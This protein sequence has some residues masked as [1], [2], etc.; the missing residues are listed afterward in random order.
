MSLF[1]RLSIH[2]SYSLHILCICPWS[3]K[4]RKFH[5]C[6]PY[7]LAFTVV[8]FVERWNKC[9]LSSH[10][11]LI[12][13]SSW[14]DYKGRTKRAVDGIYSIE[15][16]F[17][18][19]IITMCSCLHHVHYVRAR[20][21]WG[22]FLYDLFTAFWIFQHQLKAIYL[23]SICFPPCSAVEAWYP[24]PCIEYWRFTTSVLMPFAKTIT[25]A[26]SYNC[27]DLTQ[28]SARARAR[29]RAQKELKSNGLWKNTL[30]TERQ[31][32]LDK[33][34]LKTFF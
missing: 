31:Y 12:L 18:D 20:R 13:N 9:D 26:V 32:S 28:P 21:V 33:Y 4:A 11:I 1:T 3:K 19:V 30:K 2:V 15:F 24:L 25:S 6:F 17:G 27:L 29:A 14:R 34:Q 7:E 22:N 10:C 16:T 8:T 23:T 5:G